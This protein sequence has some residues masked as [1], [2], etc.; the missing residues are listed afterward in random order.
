PGRDWEERLLR[1]RRG[2]PRGTEFAQGVRRPDE[3]RYSASVKLV[4][5][6]FASPYASCSA[7]C[8]ESPGAT[9]V[10]AVSATGPERPLLRRS[11]RETRCGASG[12]A[13]RGREASP[14]R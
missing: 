11:Q 5:R 9:R 8:A 3:I 6:Q 10:H 7:I 2:T 1:R 4:I 13:N 12:A 14:P